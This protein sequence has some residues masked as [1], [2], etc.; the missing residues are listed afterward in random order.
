MYGMANTG[1]TFTMFG[2]IENVSIGDK[3][4]GLILLQL[5]DLFW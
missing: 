5:K 3:N 1:K 2:D 4:P